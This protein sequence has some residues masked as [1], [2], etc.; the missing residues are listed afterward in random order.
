MVGKNNSSQNPPHSCL[1]PCEKSVANKLLNL[2]YPGI[3]GTEQPSTGIQN[4]HDT[5]PNGKSTRH[6]KLLQTTVF[7][8]LH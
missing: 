7:D 8:D 6:A 1:S 2:A 4:N 5:I 3:L